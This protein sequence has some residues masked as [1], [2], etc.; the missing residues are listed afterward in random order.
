MGSGGSTMTGGNAGASAGEPGVG[1]TRATGGGGAVTTGG[2]RASGGTG[3]IRSSGGIDG[4]A[5]TTGGQGDAGGTNTPDAA[6]DVVSTSADV[7]KDAPG[8]DAAGDVGRSCTWR[9]KTIA[10]GEIAYYDGCNACSCAS[11]GIGLWCT[12]SGCPSPDSG[13]SQ[14]TLS[15]VLT[16]GFAGG[17]VAF[18]DSSTVDASTSTYRHTR[19]Y[20]NT[21][22][23]L[24]CEMPLMPCYAS[25]GMVMNR[26]GTDLAAPEVSAAFALAQPP[27]FGR[28]MRPMDGAVF[29]VA[30][31][32][33]RGLLVGNPCPATS[34]GA[35][36]AI[37]ASVQALVDDLKYLD[38]QMLEL[39]PNLPDSCAAFT[40]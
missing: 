30:R 9:G 36:T 32:D 10:A 8:P 12:S 26:L 17:R 4:G 16:Y 23:S 22:P 27:L 31:S 14:C 6:R 39:N 13:L 37:P 19:T 35:C 28:D 33:G 25:S 1:G 18:Q 15:A 3:G 38:R 24:I 34:T 20:T 29:S 21:T 5:G 11:N 40:P 7:A 2:T